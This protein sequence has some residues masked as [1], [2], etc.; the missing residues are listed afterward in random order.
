MKQSGLG[1]F[2]PQE[3]GFWHMKVCLGCKSQRVNSTYLIISLYDLR[4]F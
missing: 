3:R 4:F 1:R 2:D